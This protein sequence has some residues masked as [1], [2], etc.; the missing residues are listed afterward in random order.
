M[1]LEKLTALAI[2]YGLSGP[3]LREWVEKER[4]DQHAKQVVQREA[5]REEDEKQKA[6]DERQK[7][8]DERRKEL[9]LLEL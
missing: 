7:A 6:A 4:A 8:A 3:E 5:S 1:N 9:L 2:Q